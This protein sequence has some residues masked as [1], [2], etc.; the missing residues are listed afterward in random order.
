MALAPAGVALGMSVTRLSDGDTFGAVR[1]W[2]FGIAALWAIGIA[3]PNAAL[4]VA[5]IC[6][7]PVLMVV[8]PFALGQWRR[9]TLWT[10]LVLL[11]VVIVAAIGGFAASR[12]PTVQ[13]IGAKSFPVTETPAHAV[14]SALS[15]STNGLPAETALAAFWLIGV[16]ACFVWRERRWLV[17]AELLIAAL[18]VGSAA[19]GSH[20]ARLF[21]GLWYNDSHRIAA[22]LV[23]VAI[24]LTTMGVLAAGEWLHR[25]AFR[26]AVRPA[27]ALA[28]PLAIGAVVATAA[29][30]QDMPSINTLVSWG[31]STSGNRQ[32]TSPQKLQFLQTVARLVP[33]S[34]VVADDPFDGTAYL[35]AQSGTHVLFPQAAPAARDTDMAYLAHNLV[36]VGQ[37]QRACDLVRRYGI[38][39]MVVAPDDY[40]KRY[41]LPGPYYGV[42][43]PAHDSGFRLIAADGAL[44]LYKIT[45]CQPGS[46]PPSPVA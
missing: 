11:A 23:V 41:Q 15:N 32:L 35:F 17:G 10:T 28:F 38:G 2:I 44:R 18:Y 29:A 9:N 19:I 20:G 25:V 43:Y 26:A 40:L 31:L 37:D 14:V 36:H 27:V 1:R 45:I 5:L 3:H 33:A 22:T 42:G 34:A 4:S 6:L 24:P 16:I 13:A 39:Y 7:I 46:P 12:S 30:A 8:G 21:T